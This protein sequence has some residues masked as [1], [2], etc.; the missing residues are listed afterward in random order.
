MYG[1]KTH[2]TYS[3]SKLC[4]ELNIILICLYPNAT[5]I[6]QPADVAIFK[7]IKLGWQREVQQWRVVNVDQQF[8][9]R[10]FAPV[11]KSVVDKYVKKETVINGFRACGLHPF[12]A[13]AIDYS[14]CLGRSDRLNENEIETSEVIT[15]NSNILRLEDFIQIVG[16]EKVKQLENF[17]KSTFTHSEDILLLYR[18]YQKLKGTANFVSIDI[19]S[20]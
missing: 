19:F 4:E 17:D 6:L 14:K 2:L 5:R 18:I 11:L 7:P 1:H 15:E 16:N 8:T 10:D 13:N 12:N 9:K 3:L 20:K